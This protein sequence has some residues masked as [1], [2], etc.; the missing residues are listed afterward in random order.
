MSRPIVKL[1]GGDPMPLWDDSH[2]T[3]LRDLVLV[4]LGERA[5]ARAERDEARAE[6][7]R[8]RDLI[9][10]AEYGT[11]GR[12]PWCSREVGMMR[13]FA[14]DHQEACVAFSAKGVVR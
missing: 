8:L 2:S 9:A 11:N 5:E 10:V 7:K 12:C 6:V 1:N 13:P 3:Q 14:V 4:L